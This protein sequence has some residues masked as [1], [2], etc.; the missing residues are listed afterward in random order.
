MAQAINACLP[1]IDFFRLESILTGDHETLDIL[2]RIAIATALED[3]LE[4]PAGLSLNEATREK[5]KR[6]AAQFRD[7]GFGEIAPKLRLVPP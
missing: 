6:L 1:N 2:E 4:S 5:A 3:Y 7:L